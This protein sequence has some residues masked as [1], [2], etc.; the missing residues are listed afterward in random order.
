MA[1][2]SNKEELLHEMDKS[3]FMLIKKLDEL[4]EQKASLKNMEG[5]AKGTQMSPRQLVSYLIG[6]GETVLSWHQQEALGQEIVFPSQ[7]YKWNQLGLLAQKFYEDYDHVKSF[8]ELKD[9]LQENYLQLI[10]LV[11]IYTDKELYQMPWYGKWTRGRMI[12]FNT[13]SPYKNAIGRI[14]KLSRA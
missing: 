13:L 5:H 3:F 11:E 9:L 8:E 12:Q 10:N 6:W 1:V 4:P 7:G 2:P 14:N